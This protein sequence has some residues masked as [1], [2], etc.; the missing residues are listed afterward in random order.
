MEDQVQITALK[1]RGWS[2]AAISRHVGRDPKTIR[3][4]LN[5]TAAGIDPSIRAKPPG[6]ESPFERFKP[7]LTQRFAD[8]PH[9][10]AVSLYEEVGKLGYSQ[11]YPSFTRHLRENELRPK[12][13]SCVGVKSR[14]TTEIVHPPG[15][16]LL[17]G[18][19]HKISNVDRGNMRRCAWPGA[20]VA[21]QG[22]TR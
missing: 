4:Y 17:C 19:P 1:K 13:A 14:L 12:C 15:E 16:E 3:S 2:I 18:N 8:D 7:Y 9:V 11:S 5:K 20:V 6:Y 10:M 22:G 21:A